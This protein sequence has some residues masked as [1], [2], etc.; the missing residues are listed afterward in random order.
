MAE[1]EERLRQI[2]ERT[3]AAEERAARG[4]A[5]G[6]AEVRRGGAPAAP[7]GD[8]A[9]R[10]RGRRARPRGRAPGG[11]GRAGGG[12]LGSG[13]PGS[14]AVRVAAL[15]A[16]SSFTVSVAAPDFGVPGSAPDA[17]AARTDPA[18]RTRAAVLDPKKA[19]LLQLGLRGRRSRL[20]RHWHQ[21]RNASGR[22]RRRGGTALRSLASPLGLAALDLLAPAL[23]APR[24]RFTCCSCAH[25]P[26]TILGT[27][28]LTRDR[29]RGDTG[30]RGRSAGGG[31]GTAAISAVG[32]AGRRSRW[33]RRDGRAGG[34]CRCG[35][36]AAACRLSPSPCCGAG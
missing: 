30:D 12:P 6:G 13:R 26:A 16:R 29:R 23:A 2:E 7:A 19:L 33:A 4:E 5:A 14:I 18:A 36:P 17:R 35:A 21:R 9:E 24:L 27:L 10:R 11:R 25:P 1:A 32:G 28:R 20:P 8:A 34:G 31:G 3:K 15:C 22:R